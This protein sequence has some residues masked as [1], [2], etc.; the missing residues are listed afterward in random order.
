MIKEDGNIH[1]PESGWGSAPPPPPP[2]LADHVYIWV[3]RDFL[4]KK[5]PIW[6]AFGSYTSLN[7]MP[8]KRKKTD[9]L[10]IMKVIY[11]LI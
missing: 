5:G 9:A 11:S 7:Q 6:I 10:A 8:Y 3:A 2:P 1:L 4:Y